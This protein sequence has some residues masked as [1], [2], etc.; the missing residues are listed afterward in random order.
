MPNIQKVEVTGVGTSETIIPI[1]GDPAIGFG[2]I[3]DGTATYSVQHTFG[4]GV[5]FDHGTV[6]G[7]SA[8]GDGNYAFPVVGIRLNVT[9][10]TGTVKL[11]TAQASG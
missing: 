5:W 3:V 9:A 6:A 2:C 10:G 1:Q 8:N 7:A 11:I 4:E